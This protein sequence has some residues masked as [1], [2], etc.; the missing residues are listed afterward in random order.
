LESSRTV[1]DP[2]ASPVGQIGKYEVL[3]LLGRGAMG[4]VL[5]ARDPVLEREVALKV[6]LPQ[7][8]AD[9]D[10]KLRF[11][12]EARAV[13][14]LTHPN[15]VTI[16]DLGYHTDGSPYI[17]ME[18][19]R[20]EDLM[21]AIAR[22]AVQGRER[23]LGIILQVLDG[24]GHAHK[25]G[26]V[27]R[28]VKPANTF[29]MDDGTVKIMDFGVARFTA[30]SM[31]ATGIVVG[32]ANYMAPEQVNGA[33]V[34]GRADLFG[35]ASMLYELLL[36]CRPFEGDGVMNTLWKIV[37]EEPALDGLA[38]P[39]LAGLAPILRRAL[40]KSVDERYQAASEFA[41][42]LRSA[43]APASVPVLADVREP[44]EQQ[45]RRAA[46][47]F[48]LANAPALVGARVEPRIPADPTP[49]FALMR[50]IQA[51]TGSG[52]LHFTHAGER[53]SLRIVRGGVAYGTSDVPGQHLGD[54]LVRYGLLEH[55][56]LERAIA[57][58]LR[59]RRR[60]GQVLVDMGALTREQIREA[61]GMQIREILS[62]ATSR[63]DGRFSFEE[64]SHDA[65]RELEAPYSLA[66]MILETARRL[67]SPELVR[68]VLGDTGRSLSLSS[69]P[70]LRPEAL[71]LTPTE[72]FVLSRV[73]GSTSARDVVGLVP[74][75]F[76]D[77]ERSLFALLCTG[78]LEYP[79]P[80]KPRTDPARAAAPPP[81]SQRRE[82]STA[83]QRLRE[84]ARLAE[85]RAAS[86]RD[87]IAA[88]QGGEARRAEILAAHARLAH[89]NHFE[90]LGLPRGC[91]T[92]DVEAVFRELA[93]T[94]HPD[95]PL[96]P[97]LED[98]REKR[99]EVYARL[100][101][102]YEVLRDLDR[103]SDY[104]ASLDGRRA[105]K[106]EPVAARPPASAA[107]ALVASLH[108][109]DAPAH[110]DLGDSIRDAQRLLRDDRTWD[111]I[112]LLEAVA[113]KSDGPYRFRAQVLLARAYLRNP[114]WTKRAEDLL[115][116]VVH[117]AP[118]HAEAY[119]VLG[120]IYRAGALRS[121]AVAMYRRALALQPAH[122]EAAEALEV[123]EPPV[124]DA[125]SSP[126]LRKLFPKRKED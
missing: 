67:Q 79:R 70:L 10:Q 112:Q 58:G 103:R 83:V 40:A 88:R 4:A 14:R 87:A 99:S 24:L 46:A 120:N 85:E 102:A 95:V 9:P 86:R 78:T 33:R 53:R 90:L 125:S 117:D 22:G 124:A 75:P 109:E 110:A 42:A 12:R 80:A 31:T 7:I 106:T 11:E 82:P 61:V 107:P 6:M 27:H 59:E 69:H 60:L 113:A 52:H 76:E 54:V 16:Y 35:A 37:H 13:A 118:D 68:G 122:P 65:G 21:Q 2:P 55:A 45:A 32:T 73:D 89:Q 1:P 51:E 39:E 105:P 44:A 30:A 8:A 36:G 64:T 57:T 3:E 91:S 97:S 41:D 25:A 100:L 38:G 48:R 116:R 104:G 92:G 74:L 114:K 108:V 84:A 111:A 98:L 28:D 34:D 15:V 93:M 19:L 119:V 115:F 17:A 63:D 18:L 47:T 29:L 23:K 50:R 49:L 123:L 126:L 121:R 72:G 62:E 101:L 96:D 81:V 26:I 20:G 5:L 43:L 77:V 56:V 71:F 66:Q 94:F